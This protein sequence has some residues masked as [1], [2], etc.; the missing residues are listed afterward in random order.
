MHRNRFAFLLAASGFVVAALGVAT[1][2]VLDRRPLPSRVASKTAASTQASGAHAAA[3]DLDDDEAQASKGRSGRIT[4]IAKNRAEVGSNAGAPPPIHVTNYVSGRVE[5]PDGRPAGGCTIDFEIQKK[6]REG[7]GWLYVQPTTGDDVSKSDGTFELRAIGHET[8]SLS[9]RTIAPPGFAHMRD[10]EPG[11]TGI[12]LV[13]QPGQNVTGRA[14]DEANA[15]LDSFLVTARALEEPQDVVAARGEKGAFVLGGLHGGHWEIRAES[16]GHSRSSPQRLALPGDEASLDLLLPRCA[17]VSGTVQLPNGQPAANARIRS[18]RPYALGLDS[19][20]DDASSGTRADT[21]GHFLL[22]ELDAG[23]QRIVATKADY[24]DNAP[25]AFELHPGDDVRDVVLV[26]Q[27]GGRLVGE[28]LDPA[29][30]P[31][32]GL[33]VVASSRELH[34]QRAVEAD[35]DGK[36]AFDALPAGKYRVVAKPT[37][38]EIE[39]LGEAGDAESAATKS[40]DASASSPP[41][42]ATSAKVSPSA[43]LS[44]AAKLSLERSAGAEIFE[45]GTTHVTIGGPSPASVRVHGT[46]AFGSRERKPFAACIVRYA[47]DGSDDAPA[48]CAVADP[49]GRYEL[50]VDAEGR[51]AL[52]VSD[53]GSASPLG[54]GLRF[55]DRVDVPADTDFEHDVILPSASVAGRV[56]LPNGSPAEGARVQLES[57]QRVAELSS[58]FST[59]FRDTDADGHFAFDGL[60]PGIYR[61]TAGSTFDHAAAGSGRG[62]T[63]AGTAVVKNLVL[64]EDR[65]VDRLELRLQAPARIEGTVTGPDGKPYAGALVFVRDD[66][67]SRLAEGYPPPTSDAAGRFAI[68]GLPPGEIRIGA[69]TD[70]LV[71]LESPRIDLRAGETSRIA[72]ELRAG[73]RLRVVVQEQDGRVVGASL[74]VADERGTIVGSAYPLPDADRADP[75]A[76]EDGARIGPIPPGRY[77]ITATNHDGASASREISVSGDEQLVTLKYGS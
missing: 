29:G 75:P 43:K 4:S 17:K 61:I 23:P 40:S 13:L 59:G 45:G 56:L 2:F 67:E 10:V 66:A 20:A 38:G 49:A 34:V 52:S 5:W 72:L 31:L 27:R 53:P 15:P 69:R 74:R 47:L 6:R 65:S 39:D 41:N 44:L 25:A 12:V 37:A 77:T 57:E 18:F 11:T 55:Y 76:P 9:A 62:R 46:I 73:T 24:A 8:I 3:P 50:F 21:D 16:S 14:T 7:D 28:V 30:F 35:E 48:R 32:P 26:L 1:V 42:A 36:F 51:Y 64:E 63:S 71:T 68:E 58:S 19:P 33:G 22:D 70:G 54:D 60:K